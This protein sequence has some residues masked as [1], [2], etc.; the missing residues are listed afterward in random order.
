MLIKILEN[1]PLYNEKH[2][3]L[4]KAGQKFKKFLISINNSTKK[5]KKD[6][7]YF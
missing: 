6:T 7:F 3:K 1:F 5:C 2:L 4:T